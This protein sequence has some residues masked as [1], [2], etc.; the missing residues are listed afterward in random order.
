MP[1][2]LAKLTYL[3]A[4]DPDSGELNAI[5]DTP[6]GSRNKFKYD[7]QLGLFK[8]GGAMPSGSF[9]PFDFGFVPSTLGEDGDSIDVLVLMDDPAF[10]GC[11]VPSRLI[12]VIEAEQTEEGQTIRNDRLIAVAADSRRHQDVRSLEKLNDTLLEEVEHF[13]VSYNE[14]KGKQFKPLKRS[15]PARAREIIEE[16]MKTFSRRQRRDGTKS[17]STKTSSGTK[18]RGR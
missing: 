9:F 8:L 7:D 1:M 4:F 16:A 11:L 6:R 15:G 2:S 18:K 12:G 3:K 10:T 13:F 14:V 5:I 17:K